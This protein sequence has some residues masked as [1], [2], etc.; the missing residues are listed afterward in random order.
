VEFKQLM[1][2][3]ITRRIRGGWTVAAAHIGMSVNALENRVYE[4]KG[5]QLSVRDS[6]ALQYLAGNTMVADWVCTQSGGTFVK[7]PEGDDIGNQEL[8]VRFNELYG[9][10]GHLSIEFNESIKDGQITDAEADK[11]KAVAAEIHK[12]TEEL[13][14]LSFKIF[15]K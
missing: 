8:L 4:K 5:Q 6:L 10:L 7:L 12:K 13:L 15:R 14:A 11:L 3:M 1:Q 9:E 2:E